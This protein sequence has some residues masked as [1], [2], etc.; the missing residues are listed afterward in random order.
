MSASL[1]YIL[2]ENQDIKRG[3]GMWEKNIVFG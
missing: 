2:E 3:N 1:F